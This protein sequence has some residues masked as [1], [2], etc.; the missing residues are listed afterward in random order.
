MITKSEKEPVIFRS[1]FR[2]TVIKVA[3]LH[4]DFEGICF[5]LHVKNIT[6]NLLTV[7]I[8]CIPKFRYLLNPDSLSYY[9][10]IKINVT[11]YEISEKVD[12]IFGDF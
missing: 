6:Y 12:A 5:Y 2:E 7:N 3:H 10:I 1:L 4:F 8:I 9:Q 11:T